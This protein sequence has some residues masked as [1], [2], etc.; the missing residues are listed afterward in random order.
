MFEVISCRSI[1][2]SFKITFF[3][4]DTLSNIVKEK[5]HF[6]YYQILNDFS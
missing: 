1:C 3:I 2:D 6:I 5:K 4:D